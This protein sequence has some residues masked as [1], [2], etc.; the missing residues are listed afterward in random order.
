MKKISLFFAI[1]L[2]L[3]ATCNPYESSVPDVTIVGTVN[4]ASGIRRQPADLIESLKDFLNL[5]LISIAEDDTT[6]LSPEAQEIIN[7]R[8]FTIGDVVLYEAILPFDNG[9]HRRYI[10]LLRAQNPNSLFISYSMFEA[11][12]IPNIWVTILNRYFDLVVVPDPYH[13]RIYKNSGVQIPIFVL[14][15]GLNFQ[16]LLQAPLHEKQNSPFTFGNLSAGLDRKN[17]PLLINAFKFAFGDREDVHLLINMRSCENRV[18][19]EIDAT[20][21]EYDLSNITVSEKC[22]SRDEYFSALSSFDCYVNLAKAEGYSIQPREA[23]ALGIPVIVSNNSAQT[24]ICNTG[25][26]LE[27]E[28]PIRQK[29]YHDTLKTHIGMNATCTVEDAA[30]AL[31]EMYENHSHYLKNAQLAREWAATTDFE[32]LRPFYLSL[33]S[34]SKIFIGEEN[35]ITPDAILTNSPKLHEKITKIISRKMLKPKEKK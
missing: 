23:M 8:D 13:V 5:N 33:L 24:T 17:F 29:A 1:F 4:L 16:K 20:L 27:V 7:N 11:T 15:I 9:K 2:P 35:L 22:L 21:E 14:P 19:K 28:T 3:I 26:V 12:R 18:K 30:K 31:L 34:P 32:Y 10:E 25:L 6:G